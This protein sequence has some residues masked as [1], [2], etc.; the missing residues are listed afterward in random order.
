M[1]ASFKGGNLQ[2]T[3]FLPTESEPGFNLRSA[4]TI[5]SFSEAKKTRVTLLK[6]CVY[7]PTSHSFIFSHS[8]SSRLWRD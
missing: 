2:I 1:L 7:Y 4:V 8:S 3:T 6:P 5:Q